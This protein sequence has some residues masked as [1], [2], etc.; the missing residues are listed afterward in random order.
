MHLLTNKVIGTHIHFL[1]CY[2]DPAT[3]GKEGTD[4]EECKCTWLA[5]QALS[6]VT[7]EQ[8]EIL[9]VSNGLGRKY[10]NQLSNI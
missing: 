9:K 5:V 3:T 6:R 1:D 4:I 8:R 10:P 2:G 7:P